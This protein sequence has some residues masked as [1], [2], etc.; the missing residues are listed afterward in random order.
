MIDVNVAVVANRH[1][2]QADETCVLAA[3]NSLA[4]ACGG[5]IV[6]DDSWI[7][8]R[9]YLA[10]ARDT[11]EPGPGDAFLKWVLVN[12]AK[13]EFC[14]R[15][16]ITPSNDDFVEFPADPDLTTFD[17]SDRKYVAVALASTLDPTILNAVDTDWWHHREALERNGVH[18]E[19]LCPQA[20]RVGR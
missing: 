12:Q 8:L 14:E 9:E 3:I 11:G 19:F 10:N 1:A 13:I 16:S 17:R 6:L 7:I 15:V 4:A 20:M 18:V 5:R 2:P